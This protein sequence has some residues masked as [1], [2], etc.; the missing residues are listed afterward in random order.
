[1]PFL[2]RFLIAV[3]CFALIVLVGAL[4]ASV[5]HAAEVDPA[6][7]VS[8]RDDASIQ[9]DVNFEVKSDA[10]LYRFDLRVTVNQGDVILSGPVDTQYERIHAGDLAGRVRG[11]VSID[12]RLKVEHNNA[13]DD[14]QLTRE[15]KAR[16]EHA[17]ALHLAASLID[18]EVVNGGAVL[19][20][21]V[22]WWSEHQA[23]AYVTFHTDGVWNVE[24]KLIVEGF[25]YPWQQFRSERNRNAD[26]V[27]PEV[28]RYLYG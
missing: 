13:Y 7:W 24:N 8:A 16:L 4:G 23:A 10:M 6:K 11:A 17:K 12:N 19:R 25:D 1:M 22:R 2:S 3:R 5:V 15:I 18:V 14:A 21:N 9:K 20:G 26:P 27:T 28:S